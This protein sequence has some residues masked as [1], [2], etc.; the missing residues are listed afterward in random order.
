MKKSIDR[1]F[2]HYGIRQ[3]DMSII[4]QVSQQ[5]DVDAEWLKENILKPYNEARNDENIDDKRLR[6]LLNSAIKKI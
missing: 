4:E 1:C 2:L 6:K 5:A 3:E